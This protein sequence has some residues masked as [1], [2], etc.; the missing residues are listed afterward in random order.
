MQLVYQPVDDDRH[1]DRGEGE[2]ADEQGHAGA[3]GALGADAIEEGDW[4]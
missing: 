3:V 2:G 1:R 4:P